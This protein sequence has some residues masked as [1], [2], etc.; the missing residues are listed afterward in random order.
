MAVDPDEELWKLWVVEAVGDPMAAIFRHTV[1]IR[2]ALLIWCVPWFCHGLQS[3]LRHG[4][5]H[6][7]AGGWVDEVVVPDHRQG[8]VDATLAPYEGRQDVTEVLDLVARITL[9]Y[10]ERSTTPFEPV[11]SSNV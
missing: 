1:L 3:S 7:N 10:V 6:V 11:H 8:T 9:R 2:R 4:Q 5:L